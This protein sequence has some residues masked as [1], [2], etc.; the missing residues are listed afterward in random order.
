V[1]R[2]GGWRWEVPIIEMRRENNK[3]EIILD[4]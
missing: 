4:I 2:W 3:A 1:W